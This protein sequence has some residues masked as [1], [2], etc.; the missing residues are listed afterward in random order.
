MR[1]RTEGERLAMAIALSEEVRELSRCGIRARH[2]DYGSQQVE[3]ALRRLTLGDPLF[4]A[5]WPTAPLMPP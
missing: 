4:Q 5:A 1:R 2:P 3:W